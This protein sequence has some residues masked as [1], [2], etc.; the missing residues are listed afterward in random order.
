MVKDKVYFGLFTDFA[1]PTVLFSGTEI[2]LVHF[3]KLLLE[4]GHSAGNIILN[5]IAGFK[6]V[7]ETKINLVVGQIAC[8]MRKIQ[9]S[10]DSNEFDWK[11][12]PAIAAKFAGLIIALAQSKSPG[13]QYL[14]CGSLDQV[15]VVVS[16]GEY[17]DMFEC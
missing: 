1:T 16:K 3:A 2:A 4:N 9:P 6:A 8:G 17:D 12:T 5:D 7:K 11:I 10:F 14:D 15:Q 13:H